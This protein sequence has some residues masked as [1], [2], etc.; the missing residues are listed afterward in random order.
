MKKPFLELPVRI[1]L[2]EKGV[3]LFLQK[4]HKVSQVR[5]SDGSLESGLLMQPV[6]AQALQGMICRAY[7]S[8]VE[9]ARTEFRSHRL[10][11]IDLNKLI[12]YAL[13]YERF[14]N[15]VHRFLLR[16]SF[17]TAWNDEHP[18]HAINTRSQF[19]ELPMRQFLGRHEALKGQAVASI[20]ARAEGR[21]TAGNGRGVD[22]KGI[23][24]RKDLER[25]FLDHL[26]AATWFL[27]LQS[28]GG[29]HGQLLEAIARLLAKFVKKVDVAD[30]LSFML[31]EMAA[32]E[33][34]AKL[35]MTARR[36]FRAGDHGNL[37][38]DEGLRSQVRAHLESHHDYLYLTWRIRPGD[39]PR[40]VRP[41][42]QVDLINKCYDFHSLKAQM[43]NTKRMNGHERSLADFYGDLPES[44]AAGEFGQ[45]YL[46]YLQQACMDLR[47]PFDS[48]VNHVGPENVTVVSLALD[49]K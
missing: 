7:V 47:M 34:S 11:L 2:T 19:S 45:Y 35:Q 16:S 31:L 20:L 23:T 32:Y 36:L 42:L 8:K 40:A 26:H 6:N 21:L 41:A 24:A 15:H 22:A 37:E 12:V 9:V 10:E 27:L 5:L 43:D 14:A 3:R 25:K 49:M 13:L 46:G 28:G 4:G 17:I 33:E 30:C 29:E 48:R 18:E 44:H 1:A 39:L 38:D